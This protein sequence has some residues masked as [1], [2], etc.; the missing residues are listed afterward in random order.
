LT[1]EPFAEGTEADGVFP[2]MNNLLSFEET[3]PEVQGYDFLFVSTPP[4][5]L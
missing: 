5:I 4:P 2:M 3:N 1:G